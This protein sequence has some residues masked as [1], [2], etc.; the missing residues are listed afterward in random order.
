MCK[1]SATVI[2]GMSPRDSS[3]MQIYSHDRRNIRHTDVHVR[4]A[5]EATERAFVRKKKGGSLE[6]PL[7][8]RLLTRR[9]PGR[10]IRGEFRGI[11]IR[12]ED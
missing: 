3:I 9:I 11:V 5:E 6:K 1:S 12:L 7:Q 4:F 2:R 8:F 10:Q